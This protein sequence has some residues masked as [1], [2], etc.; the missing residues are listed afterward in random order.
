MI[1]IGEKINATRRSIKTAIEKKDA[2]FLQAAAQAQVAAGAGYLDLNVG[3]GS[4]SP[5]E[6]IENMRWLIKIV[7]SV[8]DKPLVI[9]TPDP[10]VVRAG[11]EA[12][13]GRGAMVNSVKADKQIL[14][15]VLPLVK[16]YR[17]EVV[18]LAMSGDKISNL[19]DE[20]LA[21]CR[22]IFEAAENLAIPDDKLYFDPLVMP[23]GTGSENG[24]ITLL[25]LQRIKTEFKEAKTTLGLSNISF[26][27]PLRRLLN[28][29]FLDM[30]I[31]SGLDSV[32]M[33][34]EDKDLMAA[35]KS[36]EAVSG[37]DRF[38]RSY[39]DFYRKHKLK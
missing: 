18:C 10:E 17:A 5:A 32:I 8:V 26:G 20:R 33:D 15:G 39:I 7:Q 2:E 4:G 22:F 19:I 27:L 24:K 1:I 21:A 11:L 9:D 30:A 25:T 28:R 38:C 12:L 34:A 31:F 6:E 13:D 35:L 16:K 14:D 36:A 37:V 3:T 29:S 23:V